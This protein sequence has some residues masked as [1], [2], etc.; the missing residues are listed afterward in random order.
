MRILFLSHYFPPE[1]NAPA[2][3]VYELAKRW[4]A[5]GHA[6]QVIT[7]VPNVPNGVVYEGYRNKLKQTEYMDGIQVTRVWT[8]IAP[9][10][11]TV[12]RTLNYLSYFV[13]ALLIGCLVRRPDVVIATSPQFFCGWAGAVL[14]KI[15]RL[16]FILEIRDIWPASIVAV[17]A[18][19]EN[20]PVHFLQ[21]LERNMYAL[22]DHIVTVGECYSEALRDRG[23]PSGKISVVM[24]GVDPE[25]FRPQSPDSDLKRQLGLNHEFVC[26]YLGTVGM[27]CGL[28]VVLRAARLLEQRRRGDIHFLIVGDGAARGELQTQADQ[29]RLANVTFTGLQP[30]AMI[31]K[32]LSITDACL[33]HLRHSEVFERVMPSKIFEAAGMAKPVIIG[34]RGFARQF[35]L[36]AGAGLAVEP[37]NEQELMDAALRLADDPDLCR[38][39]GESG[40]LHVTTYYTRDRLAEE[41]LGVI[42]RIAGPTT[43]VMSGEAVAPLDGD[44]PSVVQSFGKWGSGRYARR[45]S[46]WFSG[47][48]NRT[49]GRA[50]P[51][52]EKKGHPRPA[53]AAIAAS[54]LML[55][56]S[57][58]YR[59]MAAQLGT[60]LPVTPIA[61][62]ALDTLPLQIGAWTGQD[63]P[64]D[65][66][67]V[68]RTDTDAHLNRRYSRGGLE[69]V[70]LYVGSGVRTRDLIPHRP[71]V[72][73]ILAGWTRT[74]H[75]PQ[76]VA[77]RDNTR[78]P[79]TL[80]EFSRGVL[81][82][83]RLTVLH[84]YLV[85]G[86][87]CRD[88]SEWR[89]RYWQVGSVTQVQIVIASE[90]L[91]T[92]AAAKV[93]SGFAVD[94]APRIRELL[95]RA[96]NDRQAVITAS[97]P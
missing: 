89:Y 42:E 19:R 95:D 24:N 15:R 73:Y 74:G 16:P 49:A 9:N 37:E 18:M 46:L 84:Y 63:V 31:P 96:E 65:Q 83:T 82:R 50:G 79:C 25:V 5:A 13:N 12:R 92:E 78:L 38:T 68:R 85:D 88:L 53:L 45:F 61:R 22:A 44:R 93:V 58:A 14:A 27:A 1:G 69:T 86:Q 21:G 20:L 77:L 56:C 3:R 67:I 28:D 35:V 70:S 75:R 76:E 10:R 66:E 4:V 57:W 36:N 30:K 47:H 64:L 48:D 40:F 23:V 72:C 94:S 81:N 60:P 2:S 52:T 62:E 32:Y 33:I 8:H 80:F 11:G 91:T 55:L 59:V 6:V 7:G 54:V 43:E 29:M 41:Y 34:V 26:S 39:C 17:G 51:I 87:Y 90:N 71:E 97:S